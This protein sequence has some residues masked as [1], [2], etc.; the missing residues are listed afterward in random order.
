V[1][2][3]YL[4]FV[5]LFPQPL[6]LNYCASFSRSQGEGALVYSLTRTEDRVDSH[7]AE[8]DPVKYRSLMALHIELDCV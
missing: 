7:S 4:Q 2:E 6:I 5:S 8:V 3:P 1:L